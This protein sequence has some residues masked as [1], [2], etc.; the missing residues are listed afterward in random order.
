MEV[1]C[2]KGFR[3]MDKAERYATLKS[4]KIAYTYTVMF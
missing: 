2:V 3:K 4:F 1:F